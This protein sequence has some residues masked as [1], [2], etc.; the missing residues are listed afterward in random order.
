MS[1]RDEVG[2]LLMVLSNGVPFGGRILEIG[3]GAGVGTAWLAAGLGGRTDAQLVSVEVDSELVVA[4]QHAQW[5]PFTKLLQGD[6]SRLLK[7]LQP[8][9]LVFA[10]AAPIKYGNLEVILDALVPGGLLVIDDLGTTA[11]STDSQ[12][13]DKRILRETLRRHPLLQTADLN[14]A[15][16]VVVASRLAPMPG[17]TPIAPKVSPVMG[18]L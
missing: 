13:E 4:V 9:N 3:T 6:A 10:D 12:K 15:S 16:G 2:R 8:F 1:C 18:R 5:P 7:D 17:A 11:T 14:W